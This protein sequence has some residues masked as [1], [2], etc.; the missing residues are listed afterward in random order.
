MSRDGFWQRLCR[1]ARR[2]RGRPDWEQALGSDWPERIMHL[3]VTDHYHAK[4]GRSTGRLILSRGGGRL[5]VYLKRH[6]RMSWWRGVLATLWPRRAWSPA[7]QEYNRLQ[8]ARDIGVPVPDAVAVGEMIGPWGRLQSFLA[9]E[10]LH[11][12]LPLHEAIPLAQS[13]LDARTFLKWKRGL[14]VELARLARVLHDHRLFHKD[15]YLCHFFVHQQDTCTL[16][17]WQNRVRV[18]DLHRLTHHTWT[19][20]LWQSKDLAQLL[21]ST[22][23]VAGVTARDRLRFW[24]VYMGGRGK[25][26]AAR[27]LRRLILLRW[28]RYARH[29]ARH[30]PPGTRLA[31]APGNEAHARAS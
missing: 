18:I 19:W 25:T 15:F 10:E 9:V 13:R 2:V 23:N 20:R 31:P 3:E 30:V 27:C 16:P 26:W 12:M 7:L 17:Q 4:Q 1:G 14:I 28:R 5:S 29:N 8:W 11:D 21:Y 6:Y 22:A 24:R